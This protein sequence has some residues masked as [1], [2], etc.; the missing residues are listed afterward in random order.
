MQYRNG[1]P[2]N[3]ANYA[4]YIDFDKTPIYPNKEARL[5]WNV[6][7]GTPEIGMPGGNVTQQIGQEILIKAKNVEG[8]QINNG[9]VVY[10]YGASGSK[11]TIKL[12][13]NNSCSQAITTIAV[14]T[15]DI[16]NNQQGYV[17]SFG[18]VRDINTNSWTEGSLLYLSTSG[19]LSTSRPTL[20]KFCI[21]IGTV[22]RKHSTEGVIFVR[23]QLVANKFGDYDGGNYTEIN[24]GVVMKGTHTR[25]DDLRVPL[26]QTRQGALGKPEFDY[27]EVGFKFPQNDTSEILYTK[28]QMP[29]HWEIGTELHPHIHWK[30][31]ASQQV[32]W[33][34]DYQ[35]INIGAVVTGV[36]NTATLSTNVVT[37][38]SGS[39][40]QVTNGDTIDG[41]GKTLS[42][43]LLIKIYRDD[44]VYSGYAI[45]YDFDVHYK[46]SDMGSQEE[47]VKT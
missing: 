29:H 8:S 38:V 4:E 43:I 30:Q 33:K 21:C 23:I 19:G 1:V 47:Y 10:V 32:V 42:S 17:C 2:I 37:Y 20:D 15:E 25:W 36:W 3:Y 26:T 28:I 44:N 14:A 16:E 18:Y 40:H 11:P 46:I 35:W 24:E 9:K 13:N 39:I 7:D 22:L 27:N 34:I 12:A 45:G 41:T 31:S 6:D 5:K